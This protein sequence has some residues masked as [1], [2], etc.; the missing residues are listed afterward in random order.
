MSGAAMLHPATHALAAALADDPFYRAVTVAAGGDEALR[1][2]L[3]AGYF[4]LAWDEAQAVGEVQ[5]QGADGAALWTLPNADGAASHGAQRTAAL[6]PLL[7]AQGFAAYQAICEAMASQ[8]PTELESAWYLSILGVH[9]DARGQ[10]LA[11]RLLAPTLA[12]ADA[13]GASCFLETFNPLSLPFY[14]RL[15][16]AAAGEFLEPV[17]QRRYCLLVR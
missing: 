17:T 2:Q 10:G 7:G 8:L 4:Q 14:A 6:Q 13:A 12:R 3:L 15:G 11:Q 16:F 9:P 1:L 5:A